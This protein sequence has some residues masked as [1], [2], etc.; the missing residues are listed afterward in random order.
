MGLRIVDHGQRRVFLVQP[1]QGLP[2]LDV[3]LAVGCRQRHRQHRRRR[4]GPGQCRRRGLAGGQRIAGLD[5]IELAERDRIAGLGRGALAVMGATDAEDAGDPAALARRRLQRRAVVEMSRQHPRQRQ[6]ST[7]LQMQ[8]LE[9]IGQRILAR[10]RAEAFCRFGHAGRLMAQRLHQPQH[11]VLAQ[12]RS[13]QHRTDQSLAQFAGEI[14]EHRVARRR[15]ILQ[16][17]LHQRI[18]MVGELFQ[19]REAGFLLAVEIAAFEADHLG[20][21]VLA[22]DKGALQRQIDKT[23]D[24]IAVPDR[25][26]AQHQRNPRCRLQ[27][28][29]RLTDTLVGAVDLVEEQKAGNAEVFQLAQDDLQL[30]QLALVG[31]ADHD[32]G[33]DRRDR[34]AHVVRELDRAG[35]ID[36]GVTF[37]HELGGGGGEACAHLVM[38][39]LGA[40]VADGSSV[41]DTAGFGDGARTRQDGF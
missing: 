17:L 1:Q 22:I 40:G 34:G 20:S 35:T 25:N 3:V 26:L 16:Q 38:A 4:L 15:D 13:Q 21:L 28:R 5:A 7:V 32:G 19:H 10:G 14:V 18:V 31:L 2:K 11:A 37:A 30:R 6:F 12:R 27:G 23:R 9:H 41:V 8:R 36:E 33:I 39:G 24:Q 29:E